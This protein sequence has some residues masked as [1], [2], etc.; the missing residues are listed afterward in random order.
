MSELVA[1]EAKISHIAVVIAME[2]EAKPFLDK[3][4]LVSIG[5]R[6]KH[7]LFDLHLS[8]KAKSEAIPICALCSLFWSY[9]QQ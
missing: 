4:Q 3:Y 8:G 2:A 6:C 9:K 7:F 1:D 5:S